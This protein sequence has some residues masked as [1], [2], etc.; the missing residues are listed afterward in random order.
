MLYLNNNAIYTRLLNIFISGVFSLYLT[1]CIINSA[2]LDIFTIVKIVPFLGFL[3][4]GFRIETIKDDY[5]YEENVQVLFSRSLIVLSLLIT[6][7]ILFHIFLTIQYIIRLASFHFFYSINSLFQLFSG[8]LIFFMITNRR[9][10][11]F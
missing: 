10:I 4:L 2:E 5:T 7:I 3:S 9:F 8:H 1:Y 6:A 11:T